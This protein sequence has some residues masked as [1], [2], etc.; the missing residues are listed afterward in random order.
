MDQR[1]EA[2]LAEYHDR[3]AREAQDPELSRDE[4]LL[5]VGPE[6]GR[7]LN[8]LIKGA[9]AARILEIGTSYGYSG[10]WLAEAAAAVGGRVISLDLADYKQAY[11]RERLERAGLAQVVEHRSGDALELIPALEEHFDFVLLDCWK[12]IYAGCLDRFFPKLAKG[13][14]VAADNML[15]P[16]SAR[17]DALAYR[18]AVRA[19]PGV[20]SVLVPLG[21]GI[22]LSR[23]D[24]L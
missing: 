2:V 15:Q 1:V 22:E 23:L 19:K 12:D 21:S 10:V 17:Q 11:A 7:F 16:V 9:K 13:A 4:R 24:D 20:S 14:I 18:R 5:P 6:V 8:G 3:A